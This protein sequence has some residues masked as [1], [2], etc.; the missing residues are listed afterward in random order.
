MLVE[1]GK[2]TELTW[3]GGRRRFAL[4]RAPSLAVDRGRLLIVY[5]CMNVRT[6]PAAEASAYARLHWGVRGAGEAFDGA[7]ATAPFVA[8]GEGVS[9][10][11]T[12][13]KAGPALEDFVHAWGE[14]ARGAWRAP[15]VVEHACADRR[16]A[17]RKKLGLRGGTY[18]V[19]DRGIVG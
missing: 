3:T 16:C 12:T 10:T 5:G 17:A 13:A 11:Y 15:V 19:T 14:G 18:R 9:I 6:S 8:L 2:L 4:E 1:L 7:V